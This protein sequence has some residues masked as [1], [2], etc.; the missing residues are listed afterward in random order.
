MGIDK[1]DARRW[2]VGLAVLLLTVAAQAA[3]LAPG[4]HEQLPCGKDQPYT[5]GAYVPAA[6]AQ[7]KEPWP[8]LFLSSPGGHPVLKDWQA[9]ADARGV[10]VIGINDSH[11]GLRQSEF[12]RI[13]DAVLAAA[14][15]QLR[16]HPYLR[17]SAGA[18][19]GA[20]VSAYL[21]ERQGDRWGG[22]LMLIHG[23]NGMTPAPGV[24]TAFLVGEEDDVYPFPAVQRDFLRFREHGNPVRLESYP[25]L[26]HGGIPQADCERMMDWLLDYARL[27]QPRLDAA[28]RQA[29][30]HQ[31]QT[32][33]VTAPAIA[34][35]AR[36]R[37]EHERL[38]LLPDLKSYPGTGPVLAFWFAQ[39]LAAVKAQADLRTRYFLLCD[40][41]THPATKL[42]P[43]TDREGLQA[44]LDNCR[45]Q[46]PVKE[47]WEAQQAFAKLP[48]VRRVNTKDAP[49]II[50]AY[51]AFAE[52]HPGT[53]E[54]ERAARIADVL[55]SG[56]DKANAADR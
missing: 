34:D 37:E 2:L 1:Q 29:V 27:A 21:A 22:V 54:A 43:A 52:A 48:D 45:Q 7:S 19:G 17:F 39:R 30:R 31:V 23:G 5:F 49:G 4:L 20:M 11:N 53:P 16:L 46:S 33:L 6:Y 9:W 8:A 55:Q 35:A 12:T 14:G 28:A 32:R 51:L 50:A 44:Q 38:A 42:L 40:L 18:S 47:E 26:G 15:Q 56:L 25:G 13:Q 10:L 24:P 3:D 41:D 36:K